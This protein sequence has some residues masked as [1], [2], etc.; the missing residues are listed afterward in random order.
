MHWWVWIMLCFI[1]QTTILES[2]DSSLFSA[3]SQF[4]LETCKSLA[5]PGRVRV[6]AQ[7]AL[8]LCSAGA[9]CF[10]DF[11]KTLRILRI[12]LWSFHQYEYLLDLTRTS[13]GI[14]VIIIYIFFIVIALITITL[15]SLQL[16]ARIQVMINDWCHWLYYNYS[17]IIHYY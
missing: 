15:I 14:T 9:K 12:R 5:L 13:I 11:F 10:K 6:F 16:Y 1:A 3:K 2:V 4:T 8:R 7:G 17:L